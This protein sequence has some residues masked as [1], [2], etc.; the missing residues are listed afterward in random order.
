[1][2]LGRRS[3]Q[4]ARIAAPEPIAAGTIICNAAFAALAQGSALSHAIM[5]FMFVL[6]CLKWKTPQGGKM[7]A[8]W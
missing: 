3:E 2:A 4:P 6:L 5:L 1:L 8:L 7:R